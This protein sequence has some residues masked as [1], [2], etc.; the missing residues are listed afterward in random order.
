MARR[1][2]RR[3]SG[4]VKGVVLG[5]IG[6]LVVVLAVA[7]VGVYSYFFKPEA[8]VANGTPVNVTVS[9]GAGSEAIANQLADAGVVSNANLFLLSV[10]ESGKGSK[11]KPGAYKLAAGMPHD[12]IID[13]LVEGPAVKTYT[14]T[15]PEGWRIEQMA[16]RYAAEAQIPEDEFLTLAK[17]G[18]KEFA[19]NHPYLADAYNGSLEGFLFPKTYTIRDGSSAR[20][21]I[22]MMLDQFD[23]EIASV[24][25]AAAAKKNLTLSDVVNIAAI[26]E[27]ETKLAEERPKVASVIYNR[28]HLKMRL[29]MCSTVVYVLNKKEMRLTIAETRVDSPY[30]TY[31]NAGLPPGPIA[32]PGLSSLQAAAHPADTKYIYYVLTGKNGSHTFAKNNADFLTAKRKSKEV[33]GK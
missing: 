25:L 14:V 16:A 11:L 18:A 29:Q 10:K 15:I 22:E 21:V 4:A 3:D 32:S 24:D 1:S 20:D 9:K 23:K 2:G 13:V 8:K 19:G 33:F 12:K 17:T 28:L 6:L 31:I 30:N 7:G 5:V 26:V 27:R